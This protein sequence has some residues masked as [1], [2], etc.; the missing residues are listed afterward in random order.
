MEERFLRPASA[1]T[2]AGPSLARRALDGFLYFARLALAVTAVIAALGLLIGMLTGHDALTSLVYGLWIGGGT[3]LV[4]GGAGGGG[5][6][7]G[8]V[9]ARQTPGRR[10]LPDQIDPLG[11]ILL[12]AV[13][14]GIGVVI[15]VLTH[16][17]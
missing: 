2:P 10:L 16:R 3:L 4:F 13:P 7:G 6:R 14:L 12:G 11:L 1:A 17:S 8:G 9:A 5:L 15:A